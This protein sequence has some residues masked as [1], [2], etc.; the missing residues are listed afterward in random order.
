M[1]SDDPGRIA[2][3]PPGRPPGKGLAQTSRRKVSSGC[4]GRVE[5][6]VVALGRLTNPQTKMFIRGSGASPDPPPNLTCKLLEPEINHR[7]VNI[8]STQCRI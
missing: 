3:I 2:L 5:G 7:D 8:V 4:V 1:L 6:Y